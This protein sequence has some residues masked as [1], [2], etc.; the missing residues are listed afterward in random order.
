MEP[1][2]IPEPTRRSRL[3]VGGKLSFRG[4]SGGPAVPED[5]ELEGWLVFGGDD[6]PPL[7]TLV[8]AGFDRVEIEIGPGKGAYLVAAAAAHP[9][10]F[11]LG[12]EAAPTYAR[13]AAARLKTQGS[14]NGAVLVDNGKLYLEDRV[15]DAALDRLHVYYPDPW[16]KRRHRGRRFFAPDVIEVLTRVLA[17][18]GDLLVATDNAAYAGQICRVLGS[19]PLL[20]R[21]EAEE[22]RLLEQGPGHGFSPTNFERKYEQEGRILRRYAFRR[23]SDHE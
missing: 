9:D 17:D 23:V 15:A 18:D 1:S 14:R 13:I 2:S 16:P 7:S 19:C 21:D 3:H 12:I 6:P 4:R 22:Q 5:G 11:I 8:P 10:T 20:Q